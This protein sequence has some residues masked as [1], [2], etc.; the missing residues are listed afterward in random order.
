VASVDL[1]T[2][3]AAKR[4]LATTLSDKPDIVGVGIKPV[5]DGYVLK[6]NLLAAAPD[7]ALPGDI[8]G[9]DL[10]VE[11]TGPGTPDAV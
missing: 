1:R 3:R 4:H 5:A 2:A 9:V 6:V 10:F 8:D 7:I 11:I